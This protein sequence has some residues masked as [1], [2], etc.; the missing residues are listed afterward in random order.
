[1][2]NTVKK[3]EVG[4]LS[5]LVVLTCADFV[6]A[7]A[8]PLTAPEVDSSSMGAAVALLVGGYLLVVSKFRQQ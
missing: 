4:I 6:H 5:L 7:A 8:V 2:K 3:L 1:M